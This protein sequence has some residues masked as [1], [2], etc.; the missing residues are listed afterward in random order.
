MTQTDGFEEKWDTC[1]CICV[2]VYVFRFGS[3][4]EIINPNTHREEL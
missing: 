4:R 1:E 2:C 3:N